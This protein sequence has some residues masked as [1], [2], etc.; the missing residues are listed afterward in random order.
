MTDE[1]EEVRRTMLALGQPYDELDKVDV[2]ERYDTQQMSEL[3]IVHSFLAPFCFVTRKSDDKK[4]TLMFTHS[5]RF[6]FNF[7]PNEP[8]NEQE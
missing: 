6:Y 1:T 5:P 3:F 2:S 8:D 7:V 4:G